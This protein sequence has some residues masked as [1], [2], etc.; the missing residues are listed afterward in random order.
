M[1]RVFSGLPETPNQTS[2]E[3]NMKDSR[4]TLRMDRAHVRIYQGQH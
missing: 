2:A 1:L 4:A 3:M